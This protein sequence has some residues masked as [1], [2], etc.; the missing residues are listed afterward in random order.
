MGLLERLR[1]KSPEQAERERLALEAMQADMKRGIEKDSHILATAEEMR[2]RIK[3]S[4]PPAEEQVA[5]S[6]IITE[7]V[8]AL[9]D[10][11]NELFKFKSAECY[12]VEVVISQSTAAQVIGRNIP[13]YRSGWG[14]YHHI[15]SESRVSGK[16]A[17]ISLDNNGT[18]ELYDTSLGD[19][20]TSPLVVEGVFTEHEDLL[21]QTVDIRAA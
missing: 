6:S 12:D 16:I 3:G 2:K 15:D 13:V 14:E 17:R 20:S 21:V 4:I 18:I 9:C 10:R 7:G 11:E 5:V 19:P 1:G 8:V